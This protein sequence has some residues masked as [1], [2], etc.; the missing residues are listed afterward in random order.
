MDS[1]LQDWIGDIDELK[2]NPENTIRGMKESVIFLLPHRKRR[3]AIDLF[4]CCRK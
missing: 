3:L 1:D 2:E 4:R